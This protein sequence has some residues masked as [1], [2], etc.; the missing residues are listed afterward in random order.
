M[1]TMNPIQVNSNRSGTPAR[2]FAAFGLAAQGVAIRAG[3][4]AAFTSWAGLIEIVRADT[5]TDDFS[6]SHDYLTGGVSGTIWDG[7]WNQSAANVN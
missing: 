7:I 1:Q 6:T 3:L 5:V 4:A 2:I